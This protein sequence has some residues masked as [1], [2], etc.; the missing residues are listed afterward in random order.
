MYIIH[1]NF[2]GGSCVVIGKHDHSTHN[3]PLLS[4]TVCG[5]YIVVPILQIGK[6]MRCR[7]ECFE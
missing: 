1:L 5:V 3:T 6:R 2:P 7:E 4:S